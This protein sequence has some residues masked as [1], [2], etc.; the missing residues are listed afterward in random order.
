M[1]VTTPNRKTMRRSGYA[2]R[3]TAPGRWTL[4]RDANLTEKSD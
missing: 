1:T 2:L 4:S 3:K